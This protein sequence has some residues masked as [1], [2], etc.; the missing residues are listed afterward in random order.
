MFAHAAIVAIGSV[1]TAVVA[2]LRLG[3]ASDTS[4]ALSAM[5]ASGVLSCTYSTARCRSGCGG[6]GRAG[7]PCGRGSPGRRGSGG[8]VNAPPDVAPRVVSVTARKSRPSNVMFSAAV[9]PWRAPLGER[10]VLVGVGEPLADRAGVGHVA[11][12]A[13]GEDAEEAVHAVVDLLERI[14]MSR[15]A[16]I[17]SSMA[18]SAERFSSIVPSRRRCS[19]A[20]RRWRPRRW[21]GARPGF[22]ASLE[23]LA[24]DVDDTH[25]VSLRG[26]GRSAPERWGW[27]V[28]DR[29]GRGGR[30]EVSEVMRSR[31][32]G[33]S[34]P[35]GSER[36]SSSS[37]DEIRVG[38]SPRSAAS[39]TDRSS[40]PLSSARER[41]ASSAVES[42]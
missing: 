30:S 21:N 12:V 17:R 32:G 27:V 35:S 31:D 14:S 3:V 41:R 11:V 1:T 22:G 4:T 25:G 9:D 34:R 29:C 33:G 19:R 28:S 16:A 23:V 42:S 39:R 8:R 40:K 38:S 26:A 36:C 6:S 13:V 18:S 15:L 20:C 5:S 7:R 24:H 2:G 10:P 37:S